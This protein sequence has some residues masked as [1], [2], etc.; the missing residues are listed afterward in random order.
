MKNKIL[1]Q[2]VPGQGRLDPHINRMGLIED[3]QVKEGILPEGELIGTRFSQ[4][5][6][7]KT[8]SV[9]LEIDA[10]KTLFLAAFNNLCFPDVN[11]LDKVIPLQKS[12]KKNDPDNDKNDT[13]SIFR[14]CQSNYLF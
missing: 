4:P 6:L 1:E 3:V 9:I 2:H 8:D 5:I 11:T 10:G 13:E 14:K 12:T 7:N